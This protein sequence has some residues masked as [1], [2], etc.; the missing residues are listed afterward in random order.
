MIPQQK[1]YA[2][3]K[4]DTWSQLVE[5]GSNPDYPNPGQNRSQPIRID[6]KQF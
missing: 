3:K 4:Y 1:D 5:G 6:R 2:T